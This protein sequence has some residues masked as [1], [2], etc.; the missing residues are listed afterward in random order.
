VSVFSGEIHVKVVPSGNFTIGERVLAVVLPDL[1]SSCW[2]W[3][4]A[5]PWEFSSFH[6]HSA[7]RIFI[8]QPGRNLRPVVIRKDDYQPCGGEK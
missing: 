6:H 1:F 3:R 8:T 5:T 7:S 2:C 4:G